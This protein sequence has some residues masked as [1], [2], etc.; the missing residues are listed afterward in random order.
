MHLII[1]EIWRPINKQAEQFFDKKADNIISYPEITTKDYPKIVKEFYHSLS[2]NDENYIIL[3]WPVS[4]NFQIGQ[5]VGLNHFKVKLFQWNA[6]KQSYE[7][8]ENVWRN[9]LF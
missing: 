4:L 6:E 1:L 2:Q 9:V 7:E 8:L 5:V 3:S